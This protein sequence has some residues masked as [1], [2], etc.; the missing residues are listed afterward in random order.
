MSTLPPPGTYTID[1]SHTHAGFSVKHFGLAKVRGQFNDVS[2]T[3]VID[4]E[5]TKSSVTATIQTASFDSRDENRD[6]HVR[7]EELLDVEKYPTIT[8]TSTG[9]RPDGDDWIVTGD[10]TIKGVTRSVELETEFEGSLVDPYGL[11]RIAFSAETEIDRKDWG[12]DFDSVI[13]SGNLVIGKK[14]KITLEVEATAPVEA[15][16]PA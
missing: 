2:G 16:A 15:N 4:P 9:V 7:S 5:P 1:L 13:D 10:L 6:G 3:I 12:L 11:Q 14:V 8:F